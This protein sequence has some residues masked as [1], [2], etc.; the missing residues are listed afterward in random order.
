MIHVQIASQVT[1]TGVDGIRWVLVEAA[2]TP[3]L[4]AVPPA[5]VFAAAQSPVVGANAAQRPQRALSLALLKLLVMTLGVG[6]ALWLA[7][8]TLGP[9]RLPW[10]GPAGD[11]ALPRDRQPTHTVPGAVP[12]SPPASA[13]GPLLTAALSWPRESAEAAARS[14]ELA[15]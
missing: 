11:R 3:Q 9:L 1:T 8:A 2:T 7:Q 4:S 5:A 14:L 13:A 12:A 6:G 10:W 15:Q